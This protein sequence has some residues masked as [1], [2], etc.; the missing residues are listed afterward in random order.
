MSIR[1][2]VLPGPCIQTR[3]AVLSG[4]FSVAGWNRDGNG[5]TTASVVVTH[6][7]EHPLQLIGCQLSIIPQDAVLRRPTRSLKQIMF[8]KINAL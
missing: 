7:V 4:E 8:T 2:K 3:S 1:E 6:P 5:A